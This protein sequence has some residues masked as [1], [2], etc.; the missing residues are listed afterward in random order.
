MTAVLRF[1][2]ASPDELSILKQELQSVLHQKSLLKARIARLE[3]SA[4]R[5]ASVSSPTAKPLKTVVIE[6]EQSEQYNAARRA[7]IELIL[8]SDLV[9]NIAENEQEAII[10]YEEMQRCYQ[11][12]K[13]TEVAL[14]DLNR[15]FE[16]M[17][18]KFSRE[19][20]QR[21]EELIQSLE[22]QIVNQERLTEQAAEA[23]RNQQRAIRSDS[24]DGVRARL[25]Q[26]IAVLKEQ[27]QRDEAEIEEL[28]AQIEAKA[29]EVEQ[30]QA[31]YGDLE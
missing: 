17:R 31:R 10:L 30:A 20:M 24:V 23:L 28:D 1:P 14:A 7:E 21:N 4:T 25:A 2:D 22:E 26:R 11:L 15:E 3:D 8:N 5:D 27:I 6:L 29:K 19:V 13:D 12:R 16:K 18:H 9:A